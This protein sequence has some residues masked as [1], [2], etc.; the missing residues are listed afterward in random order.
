LFEVYV[1]EMFWSATMLSSP[2]S[3]SSDRKR[4]FKGLF[5]LM[6]IFSTLLHLGLLWIPTPAEKITQ[7]PEKKE[8]KTVPGPKVVRL[9]DLAKKTATRPK[10]KAIVPRSKA[11]IPRA[12]PVQPVL[13]LKPKTQQT[14]VAKQPIV[15]P[16]KVAAAPTPIPT[17]TPSASPSPQASPGDTGDYSQEFGDIARS[18]KGTATSS[19]VE[20][21]GLPRPALKEIAQFFFVNAQQFMDDWN[22]A[23]QLLPEIE[24][25][26]FREQET[27]DEVLKAV[28]Q[29]FKGYKFTKVG[30]F[31]KGSLFEVQKGSTKLFV[32][33]SPA[34]ASSVFVVWKQKPSGAV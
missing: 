24:D 1:F 21:T 9:G 18:F 14:V 25:F 3:P 20:A 28:E 19:A 22:A 32:S 33:I 17:P 27:P 31:A 5:P 29:N 13:A 7:K 16:P 2:T 8:Q 30:D 10:P 11:L 12:R 4:W 23:P 15:K 6:L 26:Q 34:K